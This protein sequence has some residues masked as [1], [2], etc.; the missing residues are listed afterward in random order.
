MS[1]AEHAELS[2]WPTPGDG[3]W[4]GTL[5]ELPLSSQIILVFLLLNG[6]TD[7]EMGNIFS[8]HLIL[9]ST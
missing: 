1:W 2:T 4:L 6:L 3:S 5:L 7:K 9:F 8:K